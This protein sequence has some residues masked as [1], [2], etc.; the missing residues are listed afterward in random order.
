[1]I[2]DLITGSLLPLQQQVIQYIGHRII[3]RAMDFIDFH[4]SQVLAYLSSDPVSLCDGRVDNRCTCL[5][6]ITRGR[7]RILH[8]L[9]YSE[10]PAIVLLTHTSKPR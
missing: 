3:L 5:N 6:G 7:V 9:M 2:P 10:R 4:I 1:M 8:R